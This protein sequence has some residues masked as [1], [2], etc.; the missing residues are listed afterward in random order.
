M[1]RFLYLRLYLYVQPVIL[2]LIPPLFYCL[3]DSLLQSLIAPM[4][5]AFVWY[6]YVLL[7]YDTAFLFHLAE[8]DVDWWSYFR[9][10]PLFVRGLLHHIIPALLLPWCQVPFPD[11]SL[12][13]HCPYPTPIAPPW[14]RRLY[15]QLKRYSGK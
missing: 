11:V 15:P 2:F 6:H 8:G 5:Q 13:F 7:L 3:S 10:Y 1:N 4:L 12:T 14:L 9:W